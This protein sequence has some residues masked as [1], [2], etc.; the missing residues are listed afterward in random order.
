M[1][2]LHFNSKY[3]CIQNIIYINITYTYICSKYL[4]QQKYEFK[5]N[6]GYLNT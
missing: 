5:V 4:I 6:K 2:I 1:G 3:L